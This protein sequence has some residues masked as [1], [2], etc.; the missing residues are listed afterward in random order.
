MPESEVP[1]KYYAVIDANVLI[2]VALKWQS[3]PGS[4][5]DLAFN[6]VI[7]PLVNTEIIECHVITRL[8]DVL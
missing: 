8:L 7:I 6:D 5:I 2:S 3:V 4:I 1:V